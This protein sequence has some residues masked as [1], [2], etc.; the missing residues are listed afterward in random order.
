MSK[1]RVGG[2]VPFSANDYPG[3]LSVV[4]FCQG[5]PWDCGYCH[6]PHLLGPAPASPLNWD[7]VLHFLEKRSGLIDSVVFSGGE[8]T[9]QSELPDAIGQVKKMGFRV[10]LHTSGAYPERLRAMLGNIDW[11]GLDI[12]A[13]FARYEEITGVTGSGERALASALLVEMDPGDFEFRTT[14]HPA[15]S[16]EEM[17]DE[18]ARELSSIGG[19]KWRIQPFSG[20]GSRICG[21]SEIRIEGLA[22]R[23]ARENLQVEVRC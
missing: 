9:L 5:C 8:P 4:V 10:G 11:V 22:C 14:L 13:P 23:L 16:S 12:K 15:L 20:R 7:E 17:L 2:L 3:A 18:V 6:N 19:G 21:T 1:L